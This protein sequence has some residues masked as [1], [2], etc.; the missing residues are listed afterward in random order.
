M[1]IYFYEFFLPLKPRAITLQNIL[2]NILYKRLRF[3]LIK[4]EPVSIK[5]KPK[6]A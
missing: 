1:D 5:P 3:S 4:I 6:C 2:S